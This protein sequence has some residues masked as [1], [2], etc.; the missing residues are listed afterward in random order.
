MSAGV[1]RASGLFTCLRFVRTIWCWERGRSQRKVGG[2]KAP[3]A[4]RAGSPGANEGRQT[5][6]LPVCVCVRLSVYLWG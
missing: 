2:P 4:R 6:V 5:V 1:H 3:T